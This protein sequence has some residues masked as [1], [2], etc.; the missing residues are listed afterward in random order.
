MI[1]ASALTL[2][3]SVALLLASVT[4][5]ILLVLVYRDWKDGKLW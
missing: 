5:I 3:V 1:S 2:L 4:P